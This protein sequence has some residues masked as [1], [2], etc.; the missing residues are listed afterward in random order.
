MWMCVAVPGRVIE[1]NGSTGKVDF[2]GNVLD[3]Q[4]GFVPA[5]IGDY[6]LVHAG[7]AIE[8]VRKDQAEEIIGLLKEMESLFHDQL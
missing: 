3:V 4:M 8:V 6:V 5:K 7:S 2:S 1:I